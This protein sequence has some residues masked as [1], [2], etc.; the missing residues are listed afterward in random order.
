MVW[1]WIVAGLL[2]LAVL[3]TLAR[4][5]VRGSRV[6]GSDTQP[7]AALFRRQLAETD[8]ELAQGRLTPDQAAAAR[9]EITRR[10]LGAAQHDDAESARASDRTADALWRIGAAIGIGAV[11]P[12]AAIAVYFAVGTPAAIDRNA[13]ATDDVPH[14]AAELAAAADRIKAHLRQEPGDLKGWTLLARTLAALSSFREARE[15]Y[16]HAI[17]LAPGETGLHAEL[18]EVQVLEAQGTVTPAARAEFAKAPD[19][20]RSRYYGAE[21]ALQ[22]GDTAGA[23]KKLQALLA[24]APAD[25]PWRQA[26]ADRLAELIPSGP[27]AGAEPAAS[28]PGPSARDLADARSMSPEQRLTMI[29]GMV[30]RL[31]ERLDQHPD[32]KEG[33][34]RLA[35]AYDVLGEPDKAQ[36]ARGRE[37]AVGAGA[38]PA[39][40]SATPPATPNDPQGWIA[41]ARSYQRLGRT[42]DALAA[43]KQAN[44]QFPGNLALLEAYMKALEGGIKDNHPSS[45]LVDLATQIN[46]LDAKEP[47]AL[48]YLGLAAAQSGDRYR[49][50]AYWTKLQDALAPGDNR[51]TL[52]QHELDGLR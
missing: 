19:D 50:A 18:G 27:A 8:A 20:P 11:L 38:P 37:A 34:A 16:A 45:E 36:A 43:L 3:A 35:H 14:G 47:D 4:P 48:W 15:A 1:F 10:M 30:D 41:R 7:V 5:L 29:R 13:A 17:A 31:A 23:S 25:A 2:T 33:W 28:S 32:D 51:R 52:V 39:R 24:D 40:P 12:V 6:A 9:T 21:A 49:A 44:A 26:V 22:A 46:A 42:A